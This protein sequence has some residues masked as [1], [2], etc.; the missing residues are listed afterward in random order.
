LHA[1]TWDQV[2]EIPAGREPIARR[3]SWLVEHIGAARGRVLDIG[4][5]TGNYAIELAKL[6]FQV[7]G[8]DFST[9][10]LANAR[11]KAVARGLENLEFRR[12]D[13]NREWP[14]P[15]G[16]Q[17]CAL[18]IYS[19]QV[20][21]D[22]DFFLSEI[23]RVLVPRGLLL[24]SVPRAGVRNANGWSNRGFDRLFSTV[25]SLVSR[26]RWV[27]RYT[28]QDLNSLLE[29]RGFEVVAVDV[30]DWSLDVMARKCGS[31]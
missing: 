19:M 8:V 31:N 15:G 5:G 10:M 2:L 11:A 21:A 7:V 12:A 14:F 6:G 9:R 27:R 22:A 18:S 4:C 3:I 25:K 13:F 1:Y 30:S 26:T 29:R 17:D 28:E 20:V 24:I 16:S 23:A